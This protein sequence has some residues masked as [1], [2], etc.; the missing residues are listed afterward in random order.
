MSRKT[1]WK[2]L[3]N[4]DLEGIPKEEI[5]LTSSAPPWKWQYEGVNFFEDLEG[6]SGKTDTDENLTKAIADLM[7]KIKDEDVVCYTDGSCEEGTRNGGAG[8]VVKIPEY[9]EETLGNPCGV[10]CSP[11]RAE[12]TA[13]DSTLKHV[14][15]KT[16]EA[17]TLDDKLRLWI[18]TDSQSSITALQSGP[19]QLNKTADSVWRSLTTLAEAK[20]TVNNKHTM[21]TRPPRYPR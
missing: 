9:P 17:G 1:A 13:L 19:C 8:A 14:I 6:C 11:Y 7:A 18:M 3:C 12:M 2:T 15:D 4:T 21:D 16:K 5:L 20:A 10:W